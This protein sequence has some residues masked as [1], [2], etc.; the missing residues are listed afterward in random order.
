MLFSQLHVINVKDCGFKFVLNF[1]CIYYIIW[2]SINDSM[3]N[4]RKKTS[5]IVYLSCKKESQYSHLNQVHFREAVR[6]EDVAFDA[7]D[8]AIGDGIGTEPLLIVS[9]V[10]FAR[11]PRLADRFSRLI[12]LWFS[13]FRWSSSAVRKKAIVVSWCLSCEQSV[14]YLVSAFQTTHSREFKISII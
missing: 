13:A 6:V 8:D 3:T 2:N 4:I 9:V 7:V 14:C 1:H 10:T 12:E 5:K 11:T